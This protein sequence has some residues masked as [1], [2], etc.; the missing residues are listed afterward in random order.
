MSNQGDRIFHFLADSQTV[1][2]YPGNPANPIN[3]G[4]HLQAGDVV[5]VRF[6][7]QFF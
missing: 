3:P 5:G 4:P 7:L 6:I 1:F 2:F